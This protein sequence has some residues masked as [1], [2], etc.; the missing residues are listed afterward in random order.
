MRRVSNS[1]YNIYIIR[2]GLKNVEFDVG[3]CDYGDETFGST[4]RA[5]LLLA[6]RG[7]C[8]IEVFGCLLVLGQLVASHFRYFTSNQPER[9]FSLLESGHVQDCSNFEATTL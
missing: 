2:Y 7:I 6:S 1:P 9:K 8:R 5:E 3:F 4:G